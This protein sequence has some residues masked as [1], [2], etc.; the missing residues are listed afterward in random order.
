MIVSKTPFRVSIGGGGTDLPFYYS[1]KG[2]ELVSAAIDKYI[3]IIVQPRHF[4]EFLLRYSS[5]EIVKNIDDI[6]HDLIRESLKLLNIDKPLEITSV[7]DLPARSGLGSSS[8]FL[9][10]LLHALHEYKNEKVSK[11]KLAEEATKIQSDILHQSA[12]LQDQY[13]TAYGGVINMKISTK[14]RVLITPI[15]TSNE[16]L[17]ELEDRLV[18]FYTGINREAEAVLRNQKETAKNDMSKINELTQIK[19]LGI[20]IRNAIESGNLRKFGQYMHLHWKIKQ[21]LSSMM[22][23]S[24]INDWYELA[25]SNGAIGG[26][27]IGAGGGGFMMFYAEHNKERLISEMVKQGLVYLKFN[28]DYDGTRIIVRN[29]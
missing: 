15:D 25:I 21:N 11:K 5:T 20:D 1:L 9:V 10:G 16:T 22:T 26:K 7:A 28:F 18:F 19:Q 13:V 23:S 6:K 3:Y 29:A 17:E 12:G 8:S 24:R 14:G 4:D 27:I 2:G